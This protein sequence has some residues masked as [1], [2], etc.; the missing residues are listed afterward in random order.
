MVDIQKNMY[1]RL[2]KF[3]HCF[4]VTTMGLDPASICLSATKVTIATN[5]RDFSNDNVPLQGT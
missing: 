4:A 5:S 1:Q 3:L 2:T